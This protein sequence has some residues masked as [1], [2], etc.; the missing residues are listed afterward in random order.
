[1]REKEPTMRPTST[2]LNLA[3]AIALL[4]STAWAAEPAPASGVGAAGAAPA[5]AAPAEAD[6]PLSPEQL[7]ALVAPIALYPDD[8]LANIMMA[9]TYPLE[10][11][12]ADRWAKKNKSLKT[13]RLAAALAKEQWDESIKSLVSTPAMLAEMS[14][15]LQWTRDLGD[16]VLAQQADVMAAVQRLREKAR[17]GGHLKTTKEQTVTVSEPVQSEGVQAAAASPVIV[18]ESAQAEVISIPYYDPGVVYGGWAYPTYPPYFW[19]AP[20]GYGY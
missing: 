12:E 2:L 13:D 5:A 18:I 14:D 8:L 16:A 17:A 4:A 1:M 20:P 9:S 11:I 10:V 3:A 19:P 7:E 6:Q 15:Q